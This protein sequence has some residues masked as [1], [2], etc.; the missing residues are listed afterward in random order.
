MGC[1][2]KALSVG[3]ILSIKD[4]GTHLSL[5]LVDLDHSLAATMVDESKGPLVAITEHFESLKFRDNDLFGCIFYLVLNGFYDKKNFRQDI[6]EQI[7]VSKEKMKNK[8]LKLYTRQKSKLATTWSSK[9]TKKDVEAHGGL[10]FWHNFL[11]ICA[12]RACYNSSKEKVMQYCNVDAI[13]QLVRPFGEE[14]GEGSNFTVQA[15]VHMISLFNEKRIKG[16][17]FES[18]VADHPLLRYLREKEQ[19]CL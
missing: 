2:C 9:I 3:D 16:T 12:F 6:A 1:Q 19:K 5:K 13:L 18:H 4:L 10:V 11:Y 15:D 8:K 17:D 14:S 7:P